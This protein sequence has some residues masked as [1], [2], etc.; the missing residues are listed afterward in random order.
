MRI[1]K[2]TDSA[3]KLPPYL[4][5]NGTPLAG[6]ISEKVFI[7]INGAKQGMIIKSKNEARPVLLFLHGGMPEYFLNQKYPSGLEEDFTVVWWEQRGAGI[8]YRS[9]ISVETIT[10]EQL[11]ADTLELTNYLRDRF[12][13]EKIYLMG[14]SH[15]SFIGIQVAARAPQLYWAYLGVAQMANQLRS[16]RLAYEY[17]LEQFKQQGNR[18]MVRRMEAAPVTLAEGTPRAYL[19]LR[20]EAMHSL[21]IGTTHDMHSVI[22]GIF[23]LSLMNREYTLM[24]KFNTWRAKARWGVSPLW[25]TMLATDLSQRVP[26]LTIPAYFFHGIYDYTNSYTEAKT[27]FEKLKAPRKGFYSFEQSA[28]SPLFEE[29]E[30]MRKIIRE[31]VLMGAN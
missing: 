25:T 23:F 3:G 31:E 5:E 27:Y 30:K 21:G 11:I 4:D 12:K 9:E 10:L 1:K 28:H 8:S 22:T 17:M 2:K 13:K 6:G 14:H 18:R 19:A 16:E 20:D 15:G 7:E 29:P 24:E 26:E